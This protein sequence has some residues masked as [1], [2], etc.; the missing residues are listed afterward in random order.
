MCGISGYIGSPNDPELSHKIITNLFSEIETRG[1]HASGFWCPNLNYTSYHKEPVKSSEIIK[2]NHWKVAI[3]NDPHMII[4]HAR[5]ASI[6]VG[7]PSNNENNHPFTNKDLSIAIAH[8]GRIPDSIYLPL[9]EKYKTLSDCDSELFLCMFDNNKDDIEE[10][11]NTLREMRI[12][13]KD[14]HMAVAI[15]ERNSKR[16]WLFRNEHRSLWTVEANGQ[17]FFF[18]TREIWNNATIGL[19]INAEPKEIMADVIYLFEQRKDK[20]FKKSFKF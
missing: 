10:R 20:V 16:L 1:K 2:R 11:L 3:S 4:C 14:S 13:L 12:L 19:K 18:S 6:G 5:D 9:K 17:V 8:N 7:S 15:G